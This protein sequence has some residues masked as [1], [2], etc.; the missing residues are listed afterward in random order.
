MGAPTLAGVL[1]FAA[2]MY[3]VSAYVV[4]QQY[5]CIYHVF[6]PSLPIALFFVLGAWVLDRFP[7]G[8]YEPMPLPCASMK[9]RTPCNLLT[10]AGLIA[11][12]IYIPFVFLYALWF[13]ESNQVLA[14]FRI[15]QSP[16]G[17]SSC[18]SAQFTNG[19]YN[20]NGFY[21]PSGLT[22]GD[23]QPTYCVY[24]TATCRWADSNGLR[25]QGYPTLPNS[26]CVDRS[27]PACNGCELATS[28]GSDYPNPAIGLANNYV[29]CED[30]STYYAS[31]TAPCPGNRLV[32]GKLV[33]LAPCAY[34]YPFW[35]AHYGYSDPL[36]AYC[37]TSF[38]S[39]TTG[40]ATAVLPLS[41]AAS[42]ND[43]WCSGEDGFSLCLPPTAVRTPTSTTDIFESALWIAACP[44]T[45][46][47]VGDGM[48]SIDEEFRR[49]RRVRRRQ[50][51]E[52]A[53][54]DSDTTD[55]EAGAGQ[56]PTV[57]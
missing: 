4:A 42:S 3:L 35:V 17:A 33:G 53:A 30:V 19:T 32:D 14:P 7:P 28:D 23:F 40:Y 37:G 54:A 48:L 13:N 52:R 24:D 38:S 27:Q 8:R 16:C 36:Q 50:A 43:V 41:Y 11:T 46:W 15:R 57:E 2:A 25:I 1:A 39:D 49:R 20:P 9:R 5:N 51:A 47:I 31:N 56:S 12:I 44:M 55:E 6:I 34:C 22:F 21:G 29:P 10:R 26:T 18:T 45:V